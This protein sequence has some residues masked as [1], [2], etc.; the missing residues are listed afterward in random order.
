[1]NDE[2]NHDVEAHLQRLG[3]A[4]SDLEQ[5]I[6]SVREISRGS[7]EP[8]P[9]ALTRPSLCSAPNCGLPGSSGAN[10]VPDLMRFG[11]VAILQVDFIELHTA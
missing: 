5:S 4:I 7:R 8:G 2:H 6:S 9:G 10:C 3:H 11:N 1:M